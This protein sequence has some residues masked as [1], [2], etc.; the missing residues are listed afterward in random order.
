MSRNIKRYSLYRKVGASVSRWFFWL[1]L[2][3]AVHKEE[4]KACKRL[5]VTAG[6]ATPRLANSRRRSFSVEE[7][8]HLRPAQ[9]WPHLLP[10]TPENSPRQEGRALVT[11][12]PGFC[13][14]VAAY[15]YGDFIPQA[16]P[17]WSLS[18]FLM[19]YKMRH[20]TTVKNNSFC[21]N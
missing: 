5:A 19:N 12:S 6:Y 15:S 2:S 13:A 14:C 7:R 16:S 3:Q 11:E 9:A 21:N 20:D 1:K 8:L 18:S 10:W 4:T 17:T